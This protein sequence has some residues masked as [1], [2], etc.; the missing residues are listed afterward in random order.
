MAGSHDDFIV[1]PNFYDGLCHFRAEA[2]PQIIMNEPL[3]REQSFDPCLRGG[4]A[5]KWER[6][7][8]DCGFELIKIV[9]ESRQGNSTRQ[10][11]KMGVD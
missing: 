9:L 4:T 10:M 6:I 5:T 8:V 1:I 7:Q 2:V 11:A 3:C